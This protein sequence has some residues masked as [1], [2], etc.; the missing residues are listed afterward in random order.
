M[1][2]QVALIE[3]IKLP[4]QR[5]PAMLPSLPAWAESL[6]GA[7]RL[8]LQLTPD[9]TSFE[10]SDVLVLPTNLMPNPT[11]RQVMAGHLDSLRSWLRETG[12]FSEGAETKVAAS[13]AKLL[14]MLAGERKSDLVEQGRSEVYL[15]VLED[16]PWWA[17]EAAVKRWF[18]HDCGTDE[19]NKPYDYKWAP[20]PGTLRKIALESVYAIGARI[21]KV[22]RVLDSRPYVDCTK[23]L[24]AGRAAMTGL[25]LVLKTGDLEGAKVLSF[26]DA[27][28]LGKEPDL[29]NSRATA[30]P[31]PA[32][33]PT[34][35][36]QEVES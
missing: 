27:V 28:A 10:K 19:R 20:D 12:E 1:S 31:L 24:E 13:V 33:Q 34:D 15:D 26:Q 8:E 30:A 32:Q 11:Q 16:V 7:V 3:P 36:Y 14:T 29:L 2:T 22:Q 6:T 25:N 21:A 9:G 23:Q 4:D 18:K 17:V 5:R 35:A